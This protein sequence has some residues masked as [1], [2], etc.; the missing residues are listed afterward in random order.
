MKKILLFITA[1][2]IAVQVTLATG[3]PVTTAGSITVCSGTTITVPVTVDNFSNVGAISLTLGYNPSLLQYQGVTLNPAISGSLVN[4]ANPGVFTLG[5]FGN[6]GINLPQGAIL[7]T[8]SFSYTGPPTG[9]TS[10]LTWA[11]TP[12]EANEYATPDGVPYNKTPFANYFINGSVTVSPTGCAPVTTAPVVMSCPSSLISVP[13]TVDN[14]N[15]VGAI[16]LTLGYNPALLQY[17]GVTLNPA[18]AGS[19][20]NGANPGVFTLGFFGNPG[21]N[22]PQGAIL[23]TLQFSYAG[24]P[25]GGTSPLTWAET[26]PEA[27]EYATPEGVPFNKSPFGNYFIN[28]SVTIAPLLDVWISAHTNVSHFGGHDGSATAGAAGGSTPYTYL[29]NNGQPSVMATGLSAGTYTVTVTDLLSCTSTATVSILQP[30]GTNPDINVTFINVTVPGNVATNDGLPAGAVYGPASLLSKPAGSNYSM[31]MAPGGTYLFTADLPGV[32]SFTVQVCTPG[33]PAPPCTGEILTITVLAPLE[34][35]NPPVVNT[36]VASSAGQ[37]VTLKTLA[38]DAAGNAGGMLNASSVA[39]V[40][41][42]EPDPLAMGILSVDH[43]TGDITFTPA[44]QFSGVATYQ[45]T[46][47]DHCSPG[48]HAP[49]AQYVRV[50]N[51]GTTEAADDYNTTPQGQSL[52]VTAAKGLLTNDSDPDLDN[53][54]V[55]TTSPIIAPG[56]GTLTIAPDGGYMFV[57]DGCYTGPVSFPYT[58]ADDGTPPSY[59]SATLYITVTPLTAEAGPDQFTCFSPVLPPIATLAATAPVSGTGVWSLAP[60]SPQASIANPGN[61]ATS[62]TYFS[63]GDY[64]LLWTVTSPSCPPVQDAMVLHVS[65]P[66]AVYAGPDPETCAGSP[67]YIG[68]SSATGECMNLAWSTSGDGFFDNVKILHPLYTPGPGDVAAGNVFLALHAYSCVSCGTGDPEDVAVLTV[69]PNPL[70]FA[71]TAS[72]VSCPGMS[73]GVTSLNISG[74]VTPYA[75]LWNDNL[76]Q[77]TPIATA[78]SAGTYTVVVTDGHGCRGSSATTVT[79]NPS[80]APVITG[81]SPVT[82]GQT[83]TVYC[84]PA[85]G[86]HLYSWSVTGGTITSGQYTHCITVT[87]GTPSAL[88]PGS[89]SVTETAGSCSGTSQVIVTLLPPPVL[90]S[91]YVTYDNDENTPLNGVTLTLSD[92]LTHAIAG[93][94]TTGPNTTG[95][96]E[97]GFYSFAGIPDGDYMLTGS[98]DGVWGG[99]NATDALVTQL[100]I[101]GS[102][103]LAGL[104]DTAADV[105]ASHS[106]SGLDALFIKFRTIGAINSYPSGDWKISEKNVIMTGSPVTQ[107]LK[108]ICFGDVNGSYIPGGFKESAVIDAGDDGVMT[109]LPGREF[110]CDIRSNRQ[111]VLGAMTLFLAYDTQR[112]EIL[113][114]AGAPDGMKF[115]TGDGRISI[116]WADIKPWEVKSND[117]LISV[118]M[119]VKEQIAEPLQVFTVGAGSEFADARGI[120]FDNFG[121]KMAKV[122]TAGGSNQG[123]LFNYPNPF[124]GSTTLAYSLPEPGRVRLELADLCGKTIRILADLEENARTHTILID[125]ATLNMPPGVYLCRLVSG[126][127]SDLLTKVCKMVCTK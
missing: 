43:N 36:D 86:D 64:T 107:E 7:F 60:G 108:A 99:N 114:V 26:P 89:V 18:I 40:P 78:L 57:P 119:R 84:T 23:F 103:P 21:I 65:N 50:G 22:L 59:A 48:L 94:T 28:G 2:L 45:Y 88:I 74:G 127:P 66:P 123:A 81:P 58:I 55:I 117:P 105:N 19:L 15:N 6:P 32:Y 8:L 41:G 101:I 111:T 80:P 93:V 110:T 104:R 100:N 75:F 47:C 37:P 92:R 14:F 62:V 49:A 25:A 79:V 61:P 90:L 67:V 71:F 13:V 113:D 82:A 115:N 96:N 11:E 5:F 126:S 29:W 30:P 39:I 109:V 38:N 9:G 125:P 116:A 24:P 124:S 106:I 51:G 118:V 12:P 120:P 1:C 35:S 4:G 56:K 73:D 77:T 20:V 83:G 87:W 3:G 46:V 91:G 98:Y 68:G 16:S 53:Q 52:S 85:N 54:V 33:S 112:F 10:P 70:P 95:N 42:T 17:Q 44:P 27:N 72:N 122:E 31:A 121:L 102:Y 69:H 97:P 34:G 63:T 76:A